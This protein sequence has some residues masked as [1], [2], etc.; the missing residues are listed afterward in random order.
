MSL[1]DKALATY[2]E[3]D[4][5]DHASA[6]GFIEIFGLPLRVEAADM[7]RSANHGAAGLDDP[8]LASLR[9]R[10]PIPASRGLS[11]VPRRPHGRSWAADLR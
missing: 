1:Y 4:A 5:F 3:G 8:L 2:D 10:S 6:V 9:R 7:A 11:A